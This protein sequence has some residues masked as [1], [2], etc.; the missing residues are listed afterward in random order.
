L[1]RVNGVLHI[2]KNTLKITRIEVPDLQSSQRRFKSGIEFQFDSLVNSSIQL[3]WGV[4]ESAFNEKVLMAFKQEYD[5]QKTTEKP[6]TAPTRSKRKGK[7][8]TNDENDRVSLLASQE[9]EE[10]DDDEIAIQIEPAP[11]NPVLSVDINEILTPDEY[12]SKTT[13]LQYNPG[14]ASRFLTPTDQMILDD[15]TEQFFTSLPLTHRRPND[16]PTEAAPATTENT[17]VELQEVAV[18]NPDQVEENKD[19]EAIVDDTVGADLRLPLLIT[20]RSNSSAASF[21]SLKR[22]GQPED[23]DFDDEIVCTYLIANFHK[24]QQQPSADSVDRRD[25]YFTVKPVKMFVQTHNGLYEVQDIY[26][27][28]EEQQQQESECVIC[29]SEER[30]VT[31]LPCRHQCVCKECFQHIDKCPVC[32]ANIRE[33]VT[34]A[35]TSDN[36]ENTDQM[37]QQYVDRLVGN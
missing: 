34:T 21:S 25:H 27:T 16:T 6:T 18:Q 24:H 33:Y 35:G 31:L 19:E 30:E 28:S 4:R 5:R 11:S 20:I 22:T 17:N 9:E 3:F 8:T 32:R 10:D 12:T 2:R 29:L 13:P 26:G 14:L 1:K 7:N 36:G 37:S 15:E 23:D